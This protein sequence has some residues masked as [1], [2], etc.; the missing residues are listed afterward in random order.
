[1][2]H[3]TRHPAILLVLPILLFTL[4]ASPAGALPLDRVLPDLFTRGWSFLTSILSGVS[5][6]IDPHGGCVA[7]DAPASILNEVGCSVDPEG[8]CGTLSAPAPILSEG[9]CSLDPN[10]RCG[11]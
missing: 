4:A 9:G 1:M 6:Q 2:P 10:G 8:R 11:Q 7:T 5:C 3:R